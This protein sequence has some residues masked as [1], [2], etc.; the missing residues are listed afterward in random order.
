MVSY[1]S[2]PAQHTTMH[3][4]GGKKAVQQRSLLHKDTEEIM[5]QNSLDAAG[6][7]L[8]DIAGPELAHI[9]MAARG[10]KKY[11]AV[12]RGLSAQDAR[13]HLTGRPTRGATLRQ[14]HGLT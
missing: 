5:T 4:K 11:Y 13:P 8:G 14:P 6:A 7:R 10:P 1:S 2:C 12:H 3:G 9:E